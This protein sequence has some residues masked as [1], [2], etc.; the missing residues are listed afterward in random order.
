METLR[1]LSL[2]LLIL[3]VGIFIL[4][5]VLSSSC[6]DTDNTNAPRAAAE[7]LFSEW[8]LC[9]Y[10]YVM[11]IID[12]LILVILQNFCI[13]AVRNHW[14]FAL[15]WRCDIFARPRPNHI[16]KIG[17]SLHTRH[18]RNNMRKYRREE[19]KFF[20]YFVSL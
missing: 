17:L 6:K 3:T 18:N 12:V 15:V 2:R 4:A 16:P 8:S 14:S 7:D 5:K 10:S 13:F 1:S 9:R 20:S 11:T 19:R